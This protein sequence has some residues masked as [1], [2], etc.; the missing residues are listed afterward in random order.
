MIKFES[1]PVSIKQLLPESNYGK[2][3]FYP[4]RRHCHRCRR[5]HRLLITS[6][7]RFVARSFG[8]GFAYAFGIGG[9]IFFYQKGCLQMRR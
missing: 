1:S 9:T 5:Y 8:G 3:H 7:F 4:S 6:L 2:P